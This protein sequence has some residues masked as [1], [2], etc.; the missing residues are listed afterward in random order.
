MMKKFRISILEEYPDILQYLLLLMEKGDM[1]NQQFVKEGMNAKT[2]E[3]I[4]AN[5]I[6][7]K[8]ITLEWRKRNGRNALYSCLTEEGKKVANL[9]QEIEQELPASLLED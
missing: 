5:L 9:L 3:K 2:V 1:Y 6:S 8:L 4:R 7:A